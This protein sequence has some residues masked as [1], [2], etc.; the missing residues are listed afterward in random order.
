MRKSF[1]AILFAA[2]SI[3]D[4]FAR[5]SIMRCTVITFHPVETLHTLRSCTVLTPSMYDSSLDSFS[6]VISLGTASVS[7]RIESRKMRTVVTSTISENTNVQ[8]GSNTFRLGANLITMAAKSTPMLCIKSPITCMIAARTFR[9]L[10]SS[11]STASAA[12][13]W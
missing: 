11:S 6:S 7:I 4:A 1:L 12:R 3:S 5:G 2:V 9:L 8:I 10:L 13:R